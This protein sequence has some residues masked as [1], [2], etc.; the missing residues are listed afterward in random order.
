MNSRTA[1]RFACTVVDI[2]NEAIPE[3]ARMRIAG[4]PRF[5]RIVPVDFWRPVPV[6]DSVT[7][8]RSIIVTQPLGVG[9]W[10]PFLPRNLKIKLAAIDV[11]EDVQ[12][13]A[14]RRGAVNW[15]FPGAEVKAQVD[16]KVI[17]V[18]FEAP[19]Q[20]QRLE[21]LEFPTAQMR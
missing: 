10:I 3:E 21:L 2:V 20:E 17:R 11:V 6:E 7:N 1:Y 18:W 9:T 5:W 16:S 8:F 15:P 19:G 4:T 13:F 12:D 14:Q